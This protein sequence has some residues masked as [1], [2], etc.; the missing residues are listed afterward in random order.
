[1]S[2]VY[3]EKRKNKYEED[4]W[5]TIKVMCDTRISFNDGIGACISKEQLDPLKKYGAVKSTI[6]A[7]EFCI[8]Y[9]GNNVFL[10]S[11]L[12]FE[13]YSKRFFSREDVLEIA[14]DIH[15]SAKDYS[16]IEFIISSAEAGELIIDC[17]KEG[18]VNTNI[19]FAW[20]GS[21]DAFSY[22]QE[23]RLDTRRHYSTDLAF[24]SVV[25]GCG[26][27]TVGL[28]PISV[29][30]NCSQQSFMYTEELGYISNKQAILSPGDA[31]PFFTSEV[32]GGLSYKIY[33][34]D[35]DNVILD[36]DQMKPAIMYSRS[37][38]YNEKDFNPQMF[39]LMLP[40]LVIQTGENELA[41]YR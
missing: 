38:R 7:P 30:Y 40:M 23:L 32:D 1:M 11:K 10:A 3:A 29:Q 33:S 8:S 37:H 2:F 13:L 31:L 34:Y 27:D 41:R 20:I 39:G 35:I 16:E 24:I 15:L 21:F 36:I 18:K 25:E 14:K 9:A 26:D 4:E 6:V 5:E 12:F 19:G 17:I 28:F 22:F